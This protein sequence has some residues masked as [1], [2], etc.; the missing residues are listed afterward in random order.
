[1]RGVQVVLDLG[2]QR[3]D[4]DD[5]RA[6]RQRREEEPGEGGDRRAGGQ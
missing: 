4:A 2:D 3:R 1:V 5:L 6:K